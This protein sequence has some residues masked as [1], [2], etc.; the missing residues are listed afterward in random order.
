MKKIVRISLI[1][2]L[3]LYMFTG[4]SENTPVESLYS[5]AKIEGRVTGNSGSSSSSSSSVEGALVSLATISSKGKIESISDVSVITD[6]NGKFIIEAPSNMASDIVII[7][8]KDKYEWKGV[9][10]SDIKPGITI[11]S[12]PLNNES[13]TEAEIYAYAKSSS[14]HVLYPDIATLVDA[15]MVS[16]LKGVQNK[17]KIVA[18]AFAE[19]AES[20]HSIIS[21]SIAGIGKEEY[22]K[23]KKIKKASQATLERNLYFATSDASAKAALDINF[24]EIAEAYLNSGADADKS[25]KLLEISHRSF[26]N[27]AVVAGPVLKFELAK[28]GALLRGRILNQAIDLKF[29][30]LNASSSDFRAIA[31][32]SV[33]LNNSIKGCKDDDKMNEAFEEFYNSLLEILATVIKSDPNA[34]SSFKLKINGHKI[35]F[36]AKINNAATYQAILLAFLDYFKDIKGEV[37][38]ELPGVAPVAIDVTSEVV[39]MTNSHI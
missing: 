21:G 2:L 12:Q 37:D 5:T 31:S 18:E 1:S 14:P 34:F 11:Y 25:I 29:K 39:A 7:A 27:K 9:V 3:M 10:T 4:C 30:V 35:K 6:K 32:L 24:N 8:K 13:D 19:E 36:K 33:K 23:M 26:S 16:K 20:Q 38:N 28:K 15:E 22:E 17:I